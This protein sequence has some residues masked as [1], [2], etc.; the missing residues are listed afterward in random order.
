MTNM[1]AKYILTLSSQIHFAT[2]TMV[3]SFLITCESLVLVS[4]PSFSARVVSPT[5]FPLFSSI[6]RSYKFTTAP[7]L[8][9]KPVQCTVCGQK[10][11]TCPRQHLLCITDLSEQCNTF[12]SWSLF[13][14]CPITFQHNG[15]TGLRRQIVDYL[16]SKA[17][18]KVLVPAL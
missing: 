6:L 14:N 15:Q 11:L 5:S 10:L 1:K 13:D 17:F 18:N 4:D 7:I 12:I 3:V 16:S 8:S 9:R 2:Q